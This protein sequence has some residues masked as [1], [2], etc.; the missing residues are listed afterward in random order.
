M[1]N[2]II[3]SILA[4]AF[5]ASFS[6]EEEGDK[7]ILK[8]DVAQNTIQPLSASSFTLMYDDSEDDFETIEWSKPDFGFPASVSYTV[9]IDKADGNFADAYELATATTNSVTLT[10]GELNSAL[11]EL[12]LEPEEAAAINIRVRSSVNDKVEPVLS[13]ELSLTVTPFATTFPPIY[14]I[15]D[16][17]GWNL[18]NALELQSTGPGT[19]ETIGTFQNNGKFRFFASP[20]WDSEQ[21]GW[22][23]F[24]GGTITGGLSDGGDGDS[25]FLFGGATGYYK[26]TVSL[27]NKTIAMEAASAP[28]LFV[29]GDAQ[30][31]NL[32]NALEMHSLGG[33]QFEVIG[34][35][36][37]NGKFRFF[38]SPDWGANQ[39]RFS[40][41]SGGTVDSD[42]GDGADG[43][44]NFLFMSASGIYK[45]TVNVNTKVITVETSNAPE[46]YIIGQDQGWNLANAFKLTWLGGGKYEGT[47]NFTNNN[48]FR[49]FDRPDWPA[50]FGNFLYFEDG[51]VSA[52]LANA[53]DGD[54]NFRFVGT[55][56][57]H[58]MSVDLYNLKVEME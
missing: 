36:Q 6:C 50:G 11:L 7:A 16:A 37:Q 44:S 31:W 20:S 32:A 40:S 33:G 48:T 8:S 21:W 15:G 42:L 47:T 19:Y 45:V 53:G 9:E 24:S 25:N 39:Y 22:S 54:S 46:L 17:Q 18:D 23:F 49:L 29:I 13:S 28:T 58:K 43:D 14:V 41:F 35:F 38:V 1:K 52:M 26:I 57:S 2:K 55:T 51:E 56:G 27:K 5:F 10:V 30:G 34:Q 12:G 4:L 3:R